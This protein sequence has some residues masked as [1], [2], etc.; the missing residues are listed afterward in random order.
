MRATVILVML[1]LGVL[2]TVG[3]PRAPASSPEVVTVAVT[4]EGVR[5][6]PMDTRTFS[7]RW[8]PV[9]GMPPMVL[10]A[11]RTPGMV[12]PMPAPMPQ[13]RPQPEKQPEKVHPR[14]TRRESNVCT[15]HGMRK[16]VTR[17]GRSWRC[18]R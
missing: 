1:P 9:N 15:R 18:R 16:Q 14:A 5:R 12:E 3:L 6:V 11:K 4:T 7:A 13:A 17:G 10:A 2:S 8:M